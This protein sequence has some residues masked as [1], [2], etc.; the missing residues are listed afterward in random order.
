MVGE[1]RH[2]VLGDL[3][4]AAAHGAFH[5][6]ALSLTQLRKCTKAVLAEHMKVWKEL[7]L[8]EALQENRAVQHVLHYSRTSDA[9]GTFSAMTTEAGKAPNTTE[10]HVQLAP[11]KAEILIIITP[12]AAT[13]SINTLMHL[14]IIF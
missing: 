14:L 7:G 12:F 4:W 10:R 2:S 8:S 3:G 6:I 9:V 13:I 11:R 5:Y 1:A